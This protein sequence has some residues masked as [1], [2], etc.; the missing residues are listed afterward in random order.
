[1]SSTTRVWICI[2][3]CA[4]VSY[5]LRVLPLTLIRK[6][7]R[8]R[9]IRSL[10]YYIPYATLAVMTVPAIFSVSESPVA[11]VMALVVTAA[12]AW[13]S[14]NLF[15]SAAAASLTVLL[16]QMAVSL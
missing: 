8:S 6:P 5:A 1:M 11:G 12:V 4:G 3:V 10:L 7:I 2:L 9:F 16:V 14:S 13:F 15:L